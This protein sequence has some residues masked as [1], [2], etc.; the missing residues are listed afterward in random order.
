[1]ILRKRN[2][3][4]KRSLDEKQKLFPVRCDE[5]CIP[6]R[7]TINCMW[8]FITVILIF[9][10][11]Q[12]IGI[13]IVANGLAMP[14]LLGASAVLL[15]AEV[16]GNLADRNSAWLKYFFVLMSVIAVAVV[17]IFLT[18]HTVLASVV[19]L[20]IAAQYSQQ[21][22]LRFAY[23]LTIISIFAI[24]ILGYK[25]GLCDA[26]MVMLTVKN[27]GDYG[28]HLLSKVFALSERWDSIILFYAIPRSLI[29]TSFVPMINAIVKN[30]KEMIMRDIEIKYSGEHDRMTGFY[31]R[32]KY[33]SM[34]EESYWKL[35]K[36]AIVFF[37]LNNLKLVNDTYGHDKGDELIR[38]A[39][40]SI[41]GAL[42]ENMDAYR[43]GGD[44]FMVVIPGGD[45]AEAESL[46]ENWQQRLKKINSLPGTAECCIAYGYAVGSG[47]E[48]DEILR[49]ADKNMYKNKA[50]GK[51]QRNGR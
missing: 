31:N 29:I 15:T 38:R 21:N 28:E 18:Y 32:E 37:D 4:K 50:S 9:A 30:R 47:K 5:D 14:G 1:M 48:F 11:M 44:E 22:V 13:C 43:F 51:S 19:P 45:E 39:A 36:A 17:G 40:D 46:I 12:Q 35:E 8:Y 27:S 2:K 6:N 16:V 49:Q 41:R 42:K 7:Y 26:N 10:A 23:I 20:L 34:L 3:N 33:A 25:Y 24:T